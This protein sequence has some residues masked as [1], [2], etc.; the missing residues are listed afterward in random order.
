MDPGD[1]WWNC[2]RGF[3]AIVKGANLKFDSHSR[4]CLAVAIKVDVASL[5]HSF[6]PTKTRLI[7]PRRLQYIFSFRSLR[8]RQPT[9]KLEPENIS[10]QIKRIKWWKNIPHQKNALLS[11]ASDDKP[12][13]PCLAFVRFILSRPISKSQCVCFACGGAKQKPRVR[14]LKITAFTPYRF[15]LISVPSATRH[16]VF[17][18]L[19]LLLLATMRGTMLKKLLICDCKTKKK[20]KINRELIGFIHEISTHNWCLVLK[21][22]FAYLWMER[23]GSRRVEV[24]FINQQRLLISKKWL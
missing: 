7:Y 6:W 15:R 4:D 24:H 1:W 20:A 17:L 9:R 12:N 21:L 11:R 22:K 19:S 16:L 5:P 10:N 13:H 2:V 14:S 18:S 23:S 8:P 3:W